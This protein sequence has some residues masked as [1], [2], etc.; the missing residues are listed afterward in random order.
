MFFDQ[1]FCLGNFLIDHTVFA[2]QIWVWFGS[3]W[4]CFVLFLFF[5]PQLFGKHIF[6]EQKLF[7]IK[8]FWDQHL[9]LKIL[10]SIF[11]RD[12]NIFPSPDL[13]KAQ[14]QANCLSLGE[15]SLNP[16]LFIILSFGLASLQEVIRNLSS[17]L[18]ALVE[19]F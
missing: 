9:G 1:K 15:P 14:L 5:E 4:F 18:E 19:F 11:L 13:N 12:Q 16:N 10:G 2:P 6:W 8:L 7:E 17:S 3:A